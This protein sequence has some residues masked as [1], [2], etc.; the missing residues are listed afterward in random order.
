MDYIHQAQTL[1]MC[2]PNPL[3]A[4]MHMW[5]SCVL[6]TL[7]YGIYTVGFTL[8]DIGAIQKSIFHMYRRMTG[9]HCFI[10]G[11]THLQMLS[12]F[13][14][15]HPLDLL[16]HAGT[17]LRTTLSQRLSNMSDTDITWTTDWTHVPHLQQLVHTA[18]HE[19]LQVSLATPA[20]EAPQQMFQCPSCDLQ[21]NSLAN[22]RRHQTQVHGRIQFR[23]NMAKVA[24]FSVRG[25]PQCAHCMESF[26]SWRNFRIHL[27]RNCCQA[28]TVQCPTASN[29]GAMSTVQAKPT[30]PL[31]TD[32]NLSLLLSKPYGLPIL[33]CIKAR[34]WDTLLQ[35]PD[36]VQD[37]T[38]YCVICG[39]FSNRP[40]ELNQHL[41]TQHHQLVPHVMTKASQLCKSQAS[42]SPCRFCQRSF[43]RVHQCPVMTQAAV[44]LVNT[45]CTGDTYA[46]PGQAVLHCDICHMQFQE[47]RLLNEHLHQLHRLD[48]Q[49][50]DPLRDLLGSDPVCSHC[51]SCFADRPAVR[52][53]I[54]L[55]QCLSFD[56][57][58]PVADLPVP[59]DWQEIIMQGQTTELRQAPMKRL[60]LTLRCQL[61]QTQFQRTGDLSLHLQTTHASLWAASQMYVPLLIASCQPQGCL[62]NPMTNA[63][64]LQ[65][66]CVPLRQL[67]MMA[68]KM[69]IP[70]YLPWKFAM[71]D[72]TQYLHA[73]AD[74]TFTPKLVE[75][76][77]TRNFPALWT[78]PLLVNALCTR[79]L[80]CGLVLHPAA[81][82]DHVLDVHSSVHV[83]FETLMPQLL[84][85]L[86]RDTTNDFQ[87]E[88]CAQI[89]NHTP[90][91]NETEQELKQRRLL[92]QIHLQHQCPALQ[93]IAALLLYGHGDQCRV[94]SRRLGDA[95]N[96]QADGA[97]SST[98]A[99]CTTRR[100]Q[101]EQE[102][103]TERGFTRRTRRRHDA[104]AEG[105]GPTSTTSGCGATSSQASRLMD[106]LHANRAPSPTSIPDSEGC[107]VETA[108]EREGG[109][110]HGYPTSAAPMS[111]HTA[112]GGDPSTQ[113][114][115]PGG[116]QGDGSVEGRGHPAWTSDPRQHLPVS[117]MEP[118]HPGAE[119][120]LT[121][122]H[123]APE[124]DQVRRAIARH[125]ARSPGDDSLP[126]HEADGGRQNHPLAMANFDASGR[127]TG[128]A[129]DPTRIDGMGT[130]RH[131]SE[132]SQPGAKSPSP[133]PSR[134][135]GEVPGEALEEGPLQ[136]TS[137]PEMTDDTP[138]RESLQQGLAALRLANTSNWCFLNASFL[139]TLWA[140][141]SVDLFSL[142]QWGP[143]STQL[144]DI[145][146]KH[147]AEP[148][149]LCSIPCIS[150]L[151]DQWQDFGR[152][153]DPVE[154]LAHMMRG[155]H[156]TG[157]NLSWEKRV[158]VGVQTNT[159]DE[160]DAFLPILLQFDPAM[161]Q[162]NHVTLRQMIRDWSSQDGMVAAF[163]N[164]TALICCQ[165]DRHVRSGKGAI[166]KCDIP[167]NFHW[168]VEIPFFDGE[169]VQI[170][171]QTYK[172]VA[173]VAHL[174]TDS[175]GHCR[176]MLKIQ[177]NATASPPHMFL[178]TDDWERPEPIWKE[179]I[180]F[181]RSITCFWLCDC[182][183]MDLLHLPEDW[184]ITQPMATP[185]APTVSAA[186]LLKLFVPGTEVE[187]IPE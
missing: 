97:S 142:E 16:F 46:A 134:T 2:A 132:T 22:L 73:V 167:V 122:T 137:H 53:H 79:C 39:V 82:R 71:Q 169:G 61:C 127:P 57:M 51:L 56:P 162:D 104:A 185:T 21:C 31:L 68:A 141:L 1:V 181:H 66:V 11:N 49:D 69:A 117:E 98:R 85:A 171:W 89:F 156:F 76:L 158:Q 133:T 59:P 88:L 24:S 161:L 146:L 72:V 116:M 62:C 187:A 3:R 118:S 27:E 154:F 91:G 9:D 47:L 54:T 184:P 34:R 78:D 19:Q 136:G 126:F 139:S 63:S 6:S 157:V 150:M 152:Q 144:A 92:A 102:A 119:N 33:E 160:G 84:D 94:H 10:T 129:D 183:G 99:L 105:N 14:L 164:S 8:T 40:Q 93:Q 165:I 172:V 128:S 103:Q 81:L 41:R 74:Q 55:G 65:H 168:G 182:D 112:L 38:N 80:C 114:P 75:T 15:P 174:G 163:T 173:A 29:R 166:T 107:R 131:E 140:Y 177:M 95:G 4:R 113:T 42:N 36:A 5:Q 64:G 123:H 153:G 135:T 87:C 138:S 26:T 175:A 45:D 176:T 35:Y 86:S 121:G 180:W 100:R 111:P 30:Y 7:V 32:S 37:L 70:L 96:L 147:E 170:N 145:L 67:G 149:D 43:K 50:W 20:H 120:N 125:P 155:L 83:E 13:S 178:L 130:P 108:E 12:K 110:N 179:P 109:S 151:L 52:Q 148:I 124:D 60:Q 159:V 25:L 28:L 115:S 90:E 143:H 44:L 186:D 18:R 48:P 106:L 58:R 77:V 23:T 101:G 17:Q